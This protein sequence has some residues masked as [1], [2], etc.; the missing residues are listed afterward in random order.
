MDVHGVVHALHDC[1]ARL[2]GM[3]LGTMWG[4]ELALAMLGE[5]GF[6]VAE[7]L[8]VD[9]DIVNNYYVARKG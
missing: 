1:L 6:A 9:D 3:G 5:A 2:D 8:D 7:K 4:E